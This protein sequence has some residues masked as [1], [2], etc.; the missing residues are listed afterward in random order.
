M[1]PKHRVVAAAAILAILAIL[2]MLLPSWA[3]A[4]GV[5][6]TLGGSL[7]GLWE[8]VQRWLGRLE[9]APSAS[10]VLGGT[11]PLL[12]ALAVTSC[13]L[14]TADGLLMEGVDEVLEQFERSASLASSEPSESD[15]YTSPRNALRLVIMGSLFLASFL[16]TLL[17]LG[18]TF[19]ATVKDSIAIHWL[20][21]T[22]AAA[23]G[24][25]LGVALLTIHRGE[26]T[27]NQ[28]AGPLIAIPLM[29]SLI[30]GICAIFTCTGILLDNVGQAGT[31]RARGVAQPFVAADANRAFARLAP[32]NSSAVRRRSD[33]SCLRP[34]PPE[35][36]G[37]ACTF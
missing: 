33:R 6:V 18:L 22:I 28:L 21:Q 31:R 1:N 14:L 32:L 8:M 20:R 23:L 36:F 4:I 7:A 37:S 13:G 29:A 10:A 34:I 17:L 16:P 2:A 19:A 35:R 11:L 30:G 24:I 3:N 26:W 27:G 15:S 5:I 12:A 9:S 25:S